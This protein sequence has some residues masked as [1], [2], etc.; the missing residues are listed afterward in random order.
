MHITGYFLFTLSLFYFFLLWQ[1]PYD[2]LRKA[3]IAGFEANTPL[4]LQIQHVGPAVPYDLFLEGIRL[5]R[6]LWS[7]V[8]PDMSVQP[9]FPGLL[10]RKIEVGLVDRGSPERL[11]L[12]YHQDPRQGGLRIQAKEWET[13]VSSG[14]EF[15]LKVSLSGEAQL[16]WEGDRVD[17]GKG[18]VWFLLRRRGMETA[19]NSKIP[20]FLNLFDMLRG[21]IQLRNGEVHLRRLELSG[22]EMSRSFQG[23]FRI[24]LQGKE[25]LPDLGFL[26]QLPMK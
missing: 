15:T 26:F 8:I 23:D 13:R 24:P 5:Q 20:P 12:E 3:I 16:Q 21:E 10:L 2:S 19:S 25:G 9:N 17:R 1:F 11:R 14:Q 18:K 6:G 7:V 4:G 22:K